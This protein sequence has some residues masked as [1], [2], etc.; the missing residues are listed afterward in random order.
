MNL[1][2]HKNL[3]SSTSFPPMGP[4]QYSCLENPMDRGAWQATVH[5]VTKSWTRLKQLSTQAQSPRSPKEGDILVG[6]CRLPKGPLV[7]DFTKQLF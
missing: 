7:N 4:H 1:G 5:R 2:I 6:G 3:G